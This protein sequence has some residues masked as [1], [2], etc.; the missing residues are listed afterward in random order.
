[1]KVL[2]LNTTDSGGGAAKASVRLCEELNRNGIEAD[3]YVEKKQLNLS[4]VK[5]LPRKEPSFYHS[6]ICEMEKKAINRAMQT[7]NNIFHSLDVHSVCDVSWINDSDY[8]AVHLHWICGT[9][10][11]K[12]IASIRKKIIWTMHDSWPCCGAEH[13]PNILENDTRWKEGYLPS[14]RPKTTKGLDLCRYVWKKKKKYLQSK[15]IHFIAPSNWEK[16]ILKES[17]L[18]GKKDCTVIPNILPFATFYPR[19]KETERKKRSLGDGYKY[20][21]FGTAY[22]MDDPR[23]LKG[24]S[25]LLKAL[26][27]L[28]KQY[29]IYLILFGPASEAFIQSL[30][31]PFY[32]GGYIQSEN[33]LA[34]LYSCCDCFV[35]SSMI[36][37]LSY[38]IYESLACGVPVAAFDTGGN[39]DLIQ[40]RING[41]LAE[42][43][44]GEDL[45]KGITH[46]LENLRSTGLSLIIN[47]SFNTE[48]I[49]TSHI[50]V[51]CG[52]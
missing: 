13:H 17:A 44:N 7:T 46:C 36:E 20:I 32:S 3:L 28:K 48:E 2:L 11:I 21:G 42:R 26:H 16:S 41:Y 29:R 31:F 37:N 40:H 34:E 45:A 9:V 4:C 15:N 49:I 23:S 19:E 52:E 47:E 12:D 35:N 1:M 39:S 18:F 30:D 43:G 5:E 8:D 25:Y 10:S 22:R 51:Y 38:T 24:L 6:T 50:K 27:L 33:E 14:N